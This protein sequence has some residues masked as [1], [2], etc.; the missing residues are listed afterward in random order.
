MF[1]SSQIKFLQNCNF[2]YFLFV[3][4]YCGR[5]GY[6]LDCRVETI[7]TGGSKILAN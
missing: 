7:L 5:P 6:R 1:L 4:S 3:F 2:A